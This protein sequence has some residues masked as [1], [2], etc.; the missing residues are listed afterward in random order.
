M[1]DET[2]S[3][4]LARWCVALDLD[5]LPQHVIEAAELH[6]LDSAGCL[7][8][9]CRLEPGKRAYA[10]AAGMAAAGVQP[11]ATL[12]G[13]RSR[14]AYLDAVQ[15]MSVAAHCG[16]LDDIHAAA[17]TCIG[18]MIV[19]ALLASAEKFGGSGRGFLESAIAGYETVAR[20]GL[21]IDA[22]RLF[23][24][25]WWPS[26]IC[27]G[28][29]VASAG[30]KFLNWRAA[31]T[32]N[33]L[34]IASLHT[35]GMI[36]GGNEG[37]TARH[38]VFGRAAQ[39]GVLSLAAAER[40]FTGPRRAFEDPRGFCLTLCP[41]PKWEYL[42]QA[43]QFHLPEVGFKPYPCARQLHAAVEALLTLAREHVLGADRIAELELSLPSQS[44][45]MVSRPTAQINRAA[46]LGSGQY[47][48]AVT[49]LRSAMDLESFAEAFLESEE[50]RRLM[51]KV[52]VTADPALDRY[53][54]Q[55]W[56]G[57]VAVKTAAGEIWSKEIIIPKGEPGNPMSP[58]EV[59]DKF[60]S[61][62][63]PVLG[64]AKAL[65]VIE[66]VQTLRERNSL[67]PLLTALRLAPS[68][69]C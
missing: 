20:I 64:N 19:P 36:T 27:G 1:A 51:R 34:G 35:G 42:R 24:R 54:P 4:K 10:L 18:G 56:P 8:A 52:K 38:L 57:R 39:S 50:V 26:T 40:G 11:E 9:G 7:L 62:A 37:A 33:A 13:S 47:V 45:A 21:A 25:G 48:M 58:K 63:A 16:E 46:M 69:G 28:I 31:D 66:E 44:A 6:V 17:G 14:A 23:A 32:A 49:A 67:E 22:P 61:L 68:A 2:L 12:F 59:K 3:D 53:F 60:F 65:S 15:A 5:H 29:G 30:A 43:E 55:Y 41:E